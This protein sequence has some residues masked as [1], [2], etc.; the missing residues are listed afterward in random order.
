MTCDISG[1]ENVVTSTFTSILSNLLTVAVIAMFQKNWLL[2]PIGMAIVP[3]F[4]VPTRLAGKASWKLAGEAQTCNDKINGILNERL[5]V[6][7]QLL[8]KLFGR[9]LDEY[10]RLEAPFDW[11]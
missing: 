8:V 6:S 9:E 2:A 3:L 11:E 10:Q 1:V 5:S 4:T 7:G